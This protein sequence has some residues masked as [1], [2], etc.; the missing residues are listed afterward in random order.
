MI[1]MRYLLVT[2]IPFTRDAQGNVITDGLWARDLAGLANAAGPIRVVAPETPAT[3]ELTTWGPNAEIAPTGG[4]LEF[5]GLPAISSRWDAWKWRAIRSVLR[6]EVSAADVVH[7]SNLFPPYLGLSYAH[8]LAVRQGKKTIF[9]VAEDFHDMLSWEWVRPAHGVQRWLRRRRLAAID[10]RVRRSAN[11]ASV[12][13]LHT[14]AAVERYRLSTRRSFAIRQPGHEAAQ[15]IA[16]ARL[17]ER[18]ASLRQ[19]RP[20]K[21]AAACRHSDLKGLDLLVRAI[22][23]LRRRGIRTSATLYGQGPQTE[24]LRKLAEEHGVADNVRFPGALPPGEAVYEALQKADLFVMPHRTTDFGRA[25]FDA[26]AAG[27]PVL[28]FRTAA[29]AETVYDG[30]DGFL[31]PLDDIQGLAER[32]AILHEHRGR[33]AAASIGARR[34]A[35]ENT[36][37]EWFR[38]RA[39]WSLGT[40]QE[41]RRAA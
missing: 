14:P 16:A 35:L 28:A 33:L 6:Q 32:I 13:L 29:S 37:T 12:T 20:L 8:D 26:M 39:E 38:L 23:L 31:T 3:A 4:G 22:A 18:L 1:A 7:S 36:R 19:D 25:F 15:V 21:L 41:S 40:L 11:T 30:Q 24:T 34:R 9:V 10:R 2:H 5:R 17:E 27:L